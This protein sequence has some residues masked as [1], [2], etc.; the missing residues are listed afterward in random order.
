[1]SV[2]A[3]LTA[4]QCRALRVLAE[5]GPGKW[6]VGGSLNYA[7][8][9]ALEARGLVRGV[10]GYGTSGSFRARLWEVEITDDG[11]EAAACCAESSS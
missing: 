7:A 10:W 3:K 5:C 11:R 6:P 2:A 4:A 8:C 9:V 1:M